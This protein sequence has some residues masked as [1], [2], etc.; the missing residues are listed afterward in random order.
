MRVRVYNIYSYYT[1]HPYTR[2]RSARSHKSQ[3]KVLSTSFKRMVFLQCKAAL[4]LLVCIC[5][6]VFVSVSGG[7]S[8]NCLLS[9]ISTIRTVFPEAQLNSCSVGL[10]LGL[11]SLLNIFEFGDLEIHT[12]PI[13]ES[14]WNVRFGYKICHEYSSKAFW[15]DCLRFNHTSVD[16]TGIHGSH[17]IDCRVEDA[18]VS[19]MG[20]YDDVSSVA[21]M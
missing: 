21:V 9:I 18:V 12:P 20:R 10:E 11:G 15:S 1:I 2:T 16:I 7:M 17:G 3:Y 8:F 5:S 6:C 14:D 13:R 19:S 4:L